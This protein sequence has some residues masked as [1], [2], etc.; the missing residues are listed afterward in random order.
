MVAFFITLAA[1]L[2]PVG[3][4]IWAWVSW[5]R[6]KLT[7]G[8]L[9]EV[10]QIFRASLR[11]K[12]FDEVERILSKNKNELR[13]L[14]ASAASVLFD[15]AMVAELVDSRSLIHLELLS[16]MQFLETLENRFAAVDVV[17]RKLL[18]SEVSPLRSAVVR[19]YGGLEN[20]AYP[21]EEQQLIDKTFQKPA[22]YVKAC[23]HYPLVISAVEEL[24]SGRL[25]SEYNDIGCDYEALQ[26]ISRRSQCPVY[27]A[28]KTEV[29]AIRAAIKEG[30][31]D[32]LYVSDLS[33]VFRAVL[34]RSNYDES[35]WDSHISNWEFPT[36][37]AYLLYE[38]GSD[39]RDMSARAVQESTSK[40]NE[41]KRVRS[42]GRIAQ[43]LARIWS[44]CVWSIADSA[45]E[46]SDRFR[47]TAVKEF[48][49]FV[50]ELGWSPSEI[51]HH[52]VDRVEGLEVW[53]DLFVT[54]LRN[55]F[56]GFPRSQNVLKD[57]VQSLD[58]G[59]RYVFDG[60]GW[61]YGEL[62]GSSHS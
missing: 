40:N 14:P 19:T 29:L 7:P 24:R 53:R 5:H 10:E 27:I 61:L 1:F 59:K 2:V 52:H 47:K 39:F 20:A 12:E 41:C 37:Y 21:E 4:G 3:A 32:D 45:T 33:D 58:H 50:L 35:V 22:W 26:G 13:Q 51:Y 54:E 60:H 48:L 34:E 38:I 6:A 43:D 62:F 46:V 16:D 28:I 17:V 11:E 8:K 18:R 36:P 49:V 42:P 9:V 31:E 23:A 15:S 44:S 25:D 56:Q 30:S 55:Q 57:A